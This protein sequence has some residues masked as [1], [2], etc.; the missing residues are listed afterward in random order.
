MLHVDRKI[1]RR[2]FIIHNCSTIKKYV[3]QEFTFGPVSCNSFEF[4]LAF[5]V[6]LE[7]MYFSHLQLCT[8]TYR[9]ALGK[10]DSLLDMLKFPRESC[11][12]VYIF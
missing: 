4:G 1:T 7:Q 2:R 9:V 6:I 3:E 5:E 12:L 8:V 10:S 11:G